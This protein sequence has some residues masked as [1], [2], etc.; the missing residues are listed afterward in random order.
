LVPQRNRYKGGGKV[1]IGKIRKCRHCTKEYQVPSKWPG[2]CS[3]ECKEKRTN[4]VRNILLIKRITNDVFFSSDRWFKLRYKALAKFGR[5][6]S[7]CG[8]INNLQ[9]DHIKPR[10]KYPNLEWALD[11]LQILCMPCNKG[12]GAVDETKW[13]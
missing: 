8:S 11:N 1:V 12:K 9:V 6:C 4:K 3:L 13:R 2:C 10:S 5:R 7:L